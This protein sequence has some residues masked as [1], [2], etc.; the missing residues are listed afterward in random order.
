MVSTRTEEP[1]VWMCGWCDEPFHEGEPMD[2][3]RPGRDWINLK[4]VGKSSL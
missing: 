4:H 1:G 2:P 3:E